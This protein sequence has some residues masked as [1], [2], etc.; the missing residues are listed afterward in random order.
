MHIVGFNY[1]YLSIR[2]FPIFLYSSG[3]SLL[4]D[5]FI[6][7]TSNWDF[8]KQ[9]TKNF[10]A[11]CLN[12]IA[13]N[14]VQQREYQSRLHGTY[15]D[16]T[17]WDSLTKAKFWLAVCLNLKLETVFKG[18]YLKN[19]MW[20]H[21]SPLPFWLLHM[22]GQITIHLDLFYLNTFTLHCIT[23]LASRLARPRTKKFLMQLEYRWN[24][25][26]LYSTFLVS[27]FIKLETFFLKAGTKLKL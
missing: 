17:F 6:A 21:V 1:F 19:C 4:N 27:P 22:N 7:H 13:W 24:E 12:I 26:R 15:S 23:N 20:I 11:V 16:K 18:L 8:V 3:T 25:G 14:R 10:S 9:S 5:G 2:T